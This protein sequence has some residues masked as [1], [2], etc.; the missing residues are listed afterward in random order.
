MIYGAY[1][2]DVSES[3]LRQLNIMSGVEVVS[4]KEGKFKDI[5]IEKGFIITHID[6]K[7]VDSKIKLIATIKIK[8]GG[9]LIEGQYPNG[10]K[11]Y[12]G[13]GL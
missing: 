5:G 3:K 11:G 6:K 9:I 2:K 4:V 1:F 7:P 10:I 12:F 8:K 13:L